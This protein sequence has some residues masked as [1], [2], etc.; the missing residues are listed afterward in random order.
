MLTKK[1]REPWGSIAA[2]SRVVPAKIIMGTTPEMQGV[3]STLKT[4]WLTSFDYEF[5][6]VIALR[7]KVMNR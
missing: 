2:L 3:F 6:L 4:N 1:V 5:F 7:R